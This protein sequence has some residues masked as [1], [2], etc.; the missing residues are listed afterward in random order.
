[1]QKN[2]QTKMYKICKKNMQNIH[3]MQNSYAHYAKQ[4]AINM[5]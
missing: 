5:Q 1:M 4:F 3:N 2:M